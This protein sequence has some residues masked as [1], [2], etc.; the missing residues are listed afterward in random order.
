MKHT[1]YVLLFLFI[2]LL[3]IFIRF[4]RLGE[5]PN[6]LDWDEV[7]QGYNAYSLLQTG[8]DEFGTVYPLTIR[9]F[10]DYKTPVFTYTSIIPVKIFGLT[11][12]GVRFPSALFGSISIIVVYAFV[13]EILRTKEYRKTIALLSMFFFAISPWSIQ[14]SRTSFDANVALFFVILSSFLFIK[15]IHKKNNWYLFLS[16][17]LF[18]VSIYTT[19]SEKVFSPLFLV[20]L[21][22]WGRKYLL[23]TK[24][25]AI[26]LII[27]YIGLNFFWIFDKT[28]TARSSGVLFTS[29]A[30]NFLNTTTQE[31]SYDKL[32]GKNFD[33][34]LHNRRL[35]YVSRYI[36]NY[37]SHFGLNTLFITGDNARHHAPGMGV[38]YLFSLPFIIL[39]MIY[40]ARNKIYD[41]Y[42]IFA[43]VLIAP[44]A[45]GFAVDAPNYQR[46]LI[47]L[48]SWQ[49]FE[50]F[51]WFYMFLFFKKMPFSYFYKTVCI[52][53]MTVNVFYY[54][55]QYWLHTNS[56]YG[57]Y[58]QYGYKESIKF[59]QMYKN[60][61]KKVFF[62]NNIEQAYI[63]YL[64][65]TKYD[66]EKY[67]LDGGSQRLTSTCYT[68]DNA[69]FGDCIDKIKRGDLYIT[70]KQLALDN[71]KLINE[72]DYTLTKESAVNIY[73]Y[74]Q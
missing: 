64:F 40:V 13:Y 24:I 26:C 20:V 32:H 52:I 7:S 69:Y 67:L 18:G 34:L 12:F 44:I 6:S 27:L 48:P 19:H 70:S 47:F 10:N 71:Y 31:Q 63:F 49:V 73:E 22:L 46:S 28:A 4:Y 41:A 5:I 66:T 36:E 55:Y 50:A 65:Y 57:K 29:A 39:G 54:S 68:I 56:E 35:V 11:P 61:K 25:I 3:G 8:K 21:F 45:S 58:W 2:V 16:I 53:F 59:A 30:G 42:L 15:G 9:S 74:L 23:Q 38:L 14:F 37:L 51:G 17:C 62:A 33:A 60:T 1:I 43:W 72:L